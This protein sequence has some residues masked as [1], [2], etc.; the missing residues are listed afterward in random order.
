MMAITTT[1]VVSNNCPF[2]SSALPFRRLFRNLKT[3]NKTA[4][5]SMTLVLLCRNLNISSVINGRFSF[6]NTF[7][8]NPI[9]LIHYRGR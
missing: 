6:R 2:I 8:C 7:H 3:D 4:P 1:R 5:I 9:I